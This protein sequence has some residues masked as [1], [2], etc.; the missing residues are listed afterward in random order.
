[1]FCKNCGHQC[2]DNDNVCSQCGTRLKAAAPA[3]PKTTGAAGFDLKPYV[4]YIALGVAVLALIFGIMNLFGT[5][6][7]T[8]TASFMGMSE[9]ES[10]PVSDL[11]EI[12]GMLQFVNIL[13]GLLMLAVA[14]VAGLYGLKELNGMP[15]YDQFIA[16]LPFGNKPPT[17]IGGAGAAAG[18]LQFIMY[19]FIKIEE[20]GFKATV[21]EYFRYF[22]KIKRRYV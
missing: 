15:Y 9:S 17:L 18:L 10:G 11:Y 7:V 1:M 6:D 2:G 19:L 16:N 21:C 8:V 5:Y 3:A 13:Y 12:S 4:S 22:F 20:Y 14:A